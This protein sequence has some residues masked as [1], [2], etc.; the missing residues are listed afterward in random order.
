MLTP[1]IRALATPGHAPGH[2]S[3]IVESKGQTLIV[4]GDLVARARGRASLLM[5]RLFLIPLA[6]IRGARAGALPRMAKPEIWS[7]GRGKGQT[8]YI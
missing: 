1:G 3:Y 5:S 4:M 8:L 2:T 7:Y 6:L